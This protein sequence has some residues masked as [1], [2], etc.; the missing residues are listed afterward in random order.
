MAYVAPSPSEMFSDATN[1]AEVAQRFEDYKSTLSGAIAEGQSGG[2]AI[3]DKQIVK[4][5][6]RGAQMANLYGN[7]EKSLGADHIAGV[8]AEM[9]AVKQMVSELNK[10]WS[11]TF[12]NSTGLVP[13]DLEAPAKLLVPRLTPL[14]NS[15][16]RTK[17]VGTAR[18][19]KRILGW[20]NSGVGGVADQTPFMNSTTASTSFG[21][22]NLRRGAKIN[23]TSD[24]GSVN[25][26][27]MG[28]SDIVDWQ[29]QFAGQ[30]FQ[31]I[32]Q[33]SQTALLWSHF[34]GEERAMLYGRGSSGNGYTGAVSAPTLATTTTATTGGTVAAGTY[35]VVVTARTG[36]GESVVSA[37]APVTTTG[38]T[39]TITVTVATEPVGALGYNLYVS[40]AAGSAASATFQTSFVGLTTTLT[41]TPSSTGAVAPVADTSADANAYDGFLTVLSNPAVSG[42]VSRNN[43]ALTT[44]NPGDEF[45]KGLLSLYQSV[46]ADPEEIW[47]DASVMKEAGDLFKTASS[48]NYRIDLDGGNVGGGYKLGSAVTGLVNQVTSRMVDLKVHPYMPTGCAIIRSR[49]LPVP[50]SEVSETTQVVNVQDYMSVDWPVIQFTYDQS[51]YQYGTLVHY[52]P[53]W[54]GAILGLK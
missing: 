25:Y 34:G 9:D 29:A 50:D 13:Y 47:V 14:R 26:V 32:R 43:A 53:A 38:S 11:V 1:K 10:E 5:D 24:N 15:L 44:A 41:T 27:E 18:K 16:T 30:G 23:Y 2:T 6:T 45:Q 51:T 12:P 39:S 28:L 19:Y 20:S 17:G 46:K 22:I 7:L 37:N 35:A 4:R 42:Y 52:A 3:R 31:D 54:S 40:Q 49:T 36:F 48:S 8:Q 21:P 33:L